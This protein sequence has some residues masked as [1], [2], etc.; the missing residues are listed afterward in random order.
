[1][2]KELG[3]SAGLL[4]LLGLLVH[5]QL[6]HADSGSESG[7]GT[8]TPIAAA[9]NKSG[10]DHQKEEP[11]EGPWLATENFFGIAS[12]SLRP[13]EDSTGFRVLLD[14]LTKPEG[15]TNTLKAG[16][17]CV[18]LGLAK[19]CLYSSAPLHRFSVVATV[20]DPSHTHLSLFLDEQTEAIERSVQ[21]LGWQFATQWLPWQDYF[22]GEETDINQRRGQRRLQREQEE[23]PGI[24]V[25]RQDVLGPKT[26]T[27][28]DSPALFVLLVPETVTAGVNIASF[29]AAMHIATILSP[30]NPVGILAPSFS[31]SFASL[32][33]VV[34]QWKPSI[35]RNVYSGSASNLGYAQAFQDNTKLSFYGGVTNSDDYK[36]AVCTVLAKYGLNQTTAVLKEDEGGFSQ[37]LGEAS[38]W[39]ALN[40]SPCKIETY[41]FPRDI[42]HLRNAYKDATNT[43]Q[44]PYSDEPARLSFT[45]Q[46][47]NRG[48]DS[49]PSF[50]DTQTPLTQEAVLANITG[51]LNRAHIHTALISASNR[52]D[53][54]FLLRALNVACP[55]TR[56]LIDGPNMLFASAAD[57]GDLTGTIFLSPYPMFFK[58]DYWLDGARDGDRI[59]FSESTIE[60]L[61]NVT[62][63]VLSDIRAVQPVD[64][65][66]RLHGYKQ[67]GRNYPGLWVLTMNRNGF[68]PIDLIDTQTGRNPNQN[69]MTWFMSN[70]K[71][72]GSPLPGFLDGLPPRGW[73]VTVFFLFIAILLLCSIFLRANFSRSAGLT[74][75]TV[76]DNHA[77]KL[78]SLLTAALSLS[79]AMWFLAWPWWNAQLPSSAQFLVRVRIL[80]ALMLAGW[81]MPLAL[82]LVV[83][84]VLLAGGLM[85]QTKW[86]DLICCAFPV[87]LYGFTLFAWYRLCALPATGLFFRF[88]SVALYSG[89]S[90]A[91]PLAIASLSFC[92]LALFHLKRYGLAGALRSRL[93][94]NAGDNSYRNGLRS[95]Y[96]KIEQ[97]MNAPWTQGL[98]AWVVRIVPGLIFVALCFLILGRNSLSAFEPVLYNWVLFLAIALIL[99]SL[100]MQSY[101]LLHVW[102][103]MREFL[104]L[105]QIHPQRRK[106]HSA[107][108]RIAKHWPRRT[109]WSLN[110]SISKGTLEREMLYRL[111]W[112]A[113]T[114]P[115]TLAVS[116]HGQTSQASSDPEKDANK[117]RELLFAASHTGKDA[118]QIGQID[119]LQDQCAKQAGSIYDDDLK[120]GEAADSGPATTPE[121][122]YLA[123][124]EDFVALQLCQFVGYLV[125]QIKRIAVSLSLSFVLLIVLF[126]SY[127]PVSPQLVA[128]LLLV[129][130]LLIGIFVWRVFSQ[131]ERDP[132]LSLI[133]NTRAGQLSGEFWTQLAALGSL[134]FLGV[135][136]HL[137]PSATQFLFQW[138]A[139]SVQQLH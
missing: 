139:P 7:P 115:K 80:K 55:D 124:C 1:M 47:P 84:S 9:K 138:V 46:D 50:S 19:E 22:N 133:G 128:R 65:K 30:A 2:T 104:D 52:L 109:I 74:W 35:N 125:D 110:K 127:S 101:D 111:D 23:M 71:G 87:L 60:G 17:L 37:S 81:L 68:F 129:M 36:A 12:D 40:H 83:I 64:K 31:G 94:I 18:L 106:L 130:L 54:L 107:I 44:N 91:L 85:R 118:Q 39:T 43:V 112:R 48:E 122:G 86:Q 93:Q 113:G 61:Y 116:A 66:L 96:E 77:P 49:I 76:T 5:M 20:A 62:Q 28:Q 11:V 59:A 95:A 51:E 53:A 90:P 67:P 15:K 78:G 8:G 27:T 21:S 92:C 103:S 82:L 131:M 75:L 89:S 13:F 3:T 88:R 42:S 114:A 108:G 57:R 38:T 132:V 135:L 119:E 56:V 58:G 45:I 14:N 10:G 100:S 16:D 134:P 25:F 97:R 4:A 117:F 72:D 137:F 105:I 70:P 69:A 98:S 26:Q 102:A 6:P 63:F 79:A 24:L 126:N 121:N 32:T 99:L 33:S 123:Y 34:N 120:W 41:V 136:G 29:H 73:L